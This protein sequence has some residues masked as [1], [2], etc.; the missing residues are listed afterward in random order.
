MVAA[1]LIRAGKPLDFDE[2]AEWVAAG[3]RRS[4]GSLMCCRGRGVSGKSPDEV[5]DALVE[6]V[7]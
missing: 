2:F 3:M 4:R 7:T 5:L 6:M 1:M